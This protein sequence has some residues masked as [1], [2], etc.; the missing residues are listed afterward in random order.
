M[1]GHSIVH[2]GLASI[3]ACVVVSWVRKETRM[4]PKQAIEAL[5]EGARDSVLVTAACACCGIVVGIL[6][7]T[8]LGVRLSHNFGGNIGWQRVSFDRD[9]WSRSPDPWYGNAYRTGLHHLRRHL[10]PKLDTDRVL[11]L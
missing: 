5:Y 7:L 9:H 10:G 1:L 2:A 6:G 11:A 8:G 4:G 3:L